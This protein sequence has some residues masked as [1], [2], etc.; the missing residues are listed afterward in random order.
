MPNKKI[1]LNPVLSLFPLWENA[2]KFKEKK[3]CSYMKEWMLKERKYKVFQYR[4]VLR[5]MQVI[6]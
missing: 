5:L 2:K 4:K 6:I 1:W 3:L